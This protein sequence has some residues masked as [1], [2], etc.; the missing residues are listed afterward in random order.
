MVEKEIDELI[1]EQEE[2]APEIEPEKIKGLDENEAF[3][4]EQLE[5]NIKLFDDEL[6]NSKQEFKSW[7]DNYPED[8]QAHEDIRRARNVINDYKK[9]LVAIQGERKFLLKLLAEF[10]TGEAEIIKKL[11][12]KVNG[13]EKREAE[14]IKKLKELMSKEDL[15]I[16]GKL[17]KGEKQEDLAKEYEKHFNTITNIKRK[18]RA[19]NEVL[20][21]YEK[22]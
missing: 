15:A 12:E 19:I 1:E 8:F 16:Y 17:E 6:I 14:I 20:K 22:S 4:W 9:L 18:V 3:V 11:K 2:I 7:I 13:Y 21:A 10:K 5:L